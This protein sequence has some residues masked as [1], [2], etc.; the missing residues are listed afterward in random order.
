MKKDY[1]KMFKDMCELYEVLEKRE[2]RYQKAYTEIFKSFPVEGRLLR[3]PKHQNR[4]FV[5]LKQFCVH[6]FFWSEGEEIPCEKCLVKKLKGRK[7][8]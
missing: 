8:L 3:H 7:G 5:D 6:G 1:K 4:I 2:P